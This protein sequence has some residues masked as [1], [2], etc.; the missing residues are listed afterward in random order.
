MLRCLGGGDW[1]KKMAQ[2]EQMALVG[3]HKSHTITI[4]I[5]TSTSA[6]GPNQKQVKRILDGAP[7]FQ[8]TLALSRLSALSRYEIRE[9][10][11]FRGFLAQR[12]SP[13]AIPITSQIPLL[14]TRTGLQITVIYILEEQRASECRSLTMTPPLITIPNELQV[15]IFCMLPDLDDALNLSRA[16]NTLSAIFRNHRKHVERR[17]IVRY[18]GAAC[19]E[20]C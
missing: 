10:A 6:A 19:S 20:P 9:V 15:S 5:W 4:S 12:F 8:Q 2:P 17:I 16:C 18:L 3:T 1:G 11:E 14:E 7:L 13:S